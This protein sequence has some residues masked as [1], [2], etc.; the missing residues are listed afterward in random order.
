MAK[1]HTYID[2]M[3][4]DLRSKIDGQFDSIDNQF[5]ALMESL[6][7][8]RKLIHDTPILGT[9]TISTLALK[10]IVPK[11]HT[12]QVTS[13]Q[14]NHIVFSILPKNTKKNKKTT[15]KHIIYILSLLAPIAINKKVFS[16]LPNKK[17]KKYSKT[18]K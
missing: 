14:L 16:I 18:K 6:S 11:N 17:R 13:S 7:N 3:T 5:K 10:L 12:S 9:T 1:S 2:I 4:Q 15:K 8:T